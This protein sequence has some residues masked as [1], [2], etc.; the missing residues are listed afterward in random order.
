MYL[1]EESLGVF[2]FCV[3]IA[4]ISVLSQYKIFNF[5][6]RIKCVMR[7]IY[8]SNINTKRLMLI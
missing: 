7:I 2:F 6:R 8:K 1:F 3:D 4:C 5:M